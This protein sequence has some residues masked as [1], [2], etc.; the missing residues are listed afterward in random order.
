MLAA[1]LF[2]AAACGGDDEGEGEDAGGGADTTEVSGTVEL[3]GWASSPE[4]TKLLK[5]VIADF[6]Q[7]YPN[8][9]VKYTPISGDYPT[10]MLAK[11]SARRPPDVF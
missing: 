4:E 1:V 10:A 2:V 8:I 11:F 7:Q 6:E 5:Q 9:K 3:S